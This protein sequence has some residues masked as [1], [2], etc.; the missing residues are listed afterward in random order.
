M[1]KV[2]STCRIRP[3]LALSSLVAVS[4]APWGAVLVK[5]CHCSDMDLPA[6]LS[7]RQRDRALGVVLGAALAD[8]V[9]ASYE[10]SAVSPGVSLSGSARDLVGGGPFDWEPGE[11]TDD[12]AMAVPILKAAAR[13]ADLS[14]D[15]TLTEIVQAWF[16]WRAGAADVGVQIQRVFT[17]A[18]TAAVA[19]DTTA[20]ASDPTDSG[21]RLGGAKVPEPATMRAAATALHEATGRTAGNG[22]LMRTAP[23]ALTAL[24]DPNGALVTARAARAISDLTHADPDAGNACV[25]W[26]LALRETVL[27]G[28]EHGVVDV[29][30]RAAG[31]ARELGALEESAAKVWLHRIHE[32][33][34]NDPAAFPKNGW[35]VH[36]FQAAVASIAAGQAYALTARGPAGTSYVHTVEV[37]INAAG[38]T[39]TVA[40]IA[41]ALAGA[42]VGGSALPFA[43]VR[44][45]HGWPGL[46]AQD[47]AALVAKASAV[48]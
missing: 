47:L 26:C 27:H 36:A 19:G 22:S 7:P 40:S 35:V 24:L 29:L 45:A 5:A 31:A 8:A 33:A 15:E 39:D 46:Q 41:G 13:G 38:D 11:W 25:L 9:G 44:S 28:A 3:N 2:T 6:R 37:A 32:A 43:W 4:R 20:D 10:F 23:V 16:E 12:T 14:S 42:E 18:A 21:V 34:A 1:T 17:D 30:E 48:H